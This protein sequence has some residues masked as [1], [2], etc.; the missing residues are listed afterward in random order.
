MLSVNL[1]TYIALHSRFLVIKRQELFD[2]WNDD[3]ENTFQEICGLL[4]VKENV[5]SIPVMEEE[6]VSLHSRDTV[7]QVTV[8]L[9]KCG[10]QPE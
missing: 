1:A 6:S 7:P 9:L 8:S 10:W 2:K 3:W 5:I 4:S